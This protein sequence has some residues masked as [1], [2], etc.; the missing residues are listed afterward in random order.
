[1]LMER[2]RLNPLY[3]Y[4]RQR[5]ALAPQE[6]HPGVVV[7]WAIYSRYFLDEVSAESVLECYMV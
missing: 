5:A 6:E 7:L 2:A 4:T 3:Q 1:M